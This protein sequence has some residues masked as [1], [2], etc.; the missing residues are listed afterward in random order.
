MLLLSF[1][2]ACLPQLGRHEAPEDEPLEPTDTLSVEAISPSYSSTLGGAEA[3][4]LGGPFDGS[5]SVTVGGNEAQVLEVE[6][7]RL[8]VELPPAEEGLRDVEVVSA[9]AAGELEDGLRYFEDG[10]GLAGTLGAIEWYELQGTYWTEDSSDFGSA[11]WGLVEPADLHYWSLFGVEED[12]CVAGAEFPSL[13]FMDTGLATT[14]LQVDGLDIELEALE[15]RTFDSLLEVGEFQERA[16]YGVELSGGEL[17]DFAIEELARTGAA[18][19]LYEPYVFG[20][21]PPELRKNELDIEWGQADADRMI[22]WVERYDEDLE[23]IIETVA[24]VARDDGS[25][26]VPGSAWSEDWDYDQWLYI[27][28]GAVREDGGTVPINNADSRVAGVY[29]LLGAASTTK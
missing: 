14:S 28:V 25:F 12:S 23:E 15:D 19:D 3:E 29:W 21:A 22:I 9:L 20:S 11:W 5:V 16:T 1:L 17:P 18:F 4:I 6:K 7:D 8:V 24:C 10:T 13:R 27:Y 26:K 2:T